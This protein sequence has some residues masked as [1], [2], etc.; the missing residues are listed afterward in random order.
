[1]DSGFTFQYVSINTG[2]LAITL[3]LMSAFTFQY[4]SINTYSSNKS[5]SASRYF[6]FQYVSINTAVSMKSL[7]IRKPFTFQYVSINTYSLVLLASDYR[8]LHSNMFLLIHGLVFAMFF[9]ILT[10]HSNMFLLIPLAVTSKLADQIFFTFQYVSI[11]TSVQQL[12]E[13]LLS[14]FTF[15]Y[16]SINTGIR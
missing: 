9:L 6:T 13:A 2:S 10:L 7:V 4:V 15:Q 3:S 11:N 5:S 16:V 14:V 1:M 8:T 12:G